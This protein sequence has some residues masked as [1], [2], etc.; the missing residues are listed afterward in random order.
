M[1]QAEMT[2]PSSFATAVT[3]IDAF[4]R[5]L[6]HHRG[7]SQLLSSLD[8]FLALQTALDAAARSLADGQLPSEPLRSNY[9][10]R[11]QTVA[12]ELHR[13]EPLLQQE[14]SRLFFQL[15]NS[16][17]CRAWLDTLSHTQ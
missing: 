3:A 1:N 4:I 12:F 15:H 8:I 16:S 13:L 7:P 5:T 17:S 10:A 14:H 6:R 2:Q 11:L 9:L